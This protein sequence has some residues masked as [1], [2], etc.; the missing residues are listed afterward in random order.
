MAVPSICALIGS[1]GMLGTAAFLGGGHGPTETVIQVAGSA[2]IM[3]SSD[4]RAEFQ[5][6]GAFQLALL[7]SPRR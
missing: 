4:L 3:C 2:M 1:E 6:A 7:R 5:R